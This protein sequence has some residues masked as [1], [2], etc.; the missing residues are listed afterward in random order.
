MESRTE[1]R[2]VIY[3]ALACA[4]VLA[5]GCGGESDDGEAPSD[6]D[7]AVATNPD[8]AASAIDELTF[9]P[10]PGVR[11]E[12]GAIPRALIDSATGT[13]YLRYH[14]GHDK[15]TA[16]STDGL[17]FGAGEPASGQ[18][19]PLAVLL[20]K[21]A[22]DGQATW[23][24][25]RWTGNSVPGNIGKDK[26]P[27]E[28]AFVSNSSTD[29]I[30]FSKDDGVRFDPPA[31]ENVGVFTSFVTAKGRVGLMYIGDLATTDANVRLAYST[32]NGESF[33]LFTDNPLGDKGK[34]DQ[35]LNQRDPIA[36][37]LPDGR[38]RIF[39]MVQGGKQ[40]PRPGVRAVGFIHSFLSTDD[41]D[42][43]VAEKGVRLS[44]SD[45]KEFDVWSLNDPCVVRLP[46]G[47]FRMYVAAMITEGP[48]KTGDK[49]A[50][51][52]GIV[53]AITGKK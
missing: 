30:H 45:F 7:A 9:T 17:N 12:A 35:G 32:D 23:R 39:T 52:W 5:V 15:L 49:S 31:T 38:I 20:P 13:V 46:D 34:H 1:F 6:A 53:S 22:A 37:V 25:Y 19:S 4:L 11:I 14:K 42:S 2:W 44:P 26:G 47:R 36:T 16:T 51:R 10:E 41:G 29:G 24:T 50:V 27:K 21:P 48:I 3:S 33:S 18:P 28:G 43:F 40:A 8:A